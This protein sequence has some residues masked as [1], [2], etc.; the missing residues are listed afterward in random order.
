V[1]RSSEPFAE[2][3]FVY[4]AL[5]EHFELLLDYIKKDDALE[6]VENKYPFVD[7]EQP[8]EEF[9][10]GV[11]DEATENRNLATETEDDKETDMFS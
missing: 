10:L 5:L 4:N 9:G 6:I 1:S 2:Q 7:E 11:F 8:Q 3:K